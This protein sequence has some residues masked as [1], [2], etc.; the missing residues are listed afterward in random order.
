MVLVIKRR[1][2][3]R[4]IISLVYLDLLM[5]AEL[6][7]ISN[8]VIYGIFLHLI[9]LF[10]LLIHSALTSDRDFSKLLLAL[11]LAPLIRIL[12]LSLPL[13]HFSYIMW[14]VLISIP[15]YIAL[16]TC[17]Y[18]QG[19]NIRDIGLIPPRLRDIP[20]EVFIVLLGIPVGLIEYHI[21]KPGMLVDLKPGLQSF[22]VP[23]I[24]LILSTGFLEEL[25]FRGVMQHHAIENMGL[26]G[27][28]Y[29]SII[30]GILHLG[31]LSIFDVI[32]A[33]TIGF[34]Y[35]LVVR[36]TG[37]IY[38]VSISHGLI[39]IVLFLIAPQLYG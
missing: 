25:I 22:I 34:I 23:S 33:F 37:S 21:L 30:F 20:I 39:N 14:F 38:G 6:L 9:T 16:F 32:L 35:S 31:N 3:N 28:F 27:L 1:T 8:F 13:S 12:S 4:F 24:I 10:L 11:I 17:I 5:S 29:I 36:K 26:Y 19:L 2:L 7:T 18:I 15:V